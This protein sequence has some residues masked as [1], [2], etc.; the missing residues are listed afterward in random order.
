MLATILL[1]VAF[2]CKFTVGRNFSASSK[3]IAGNKMAANLTH[4]FA[5]SKL[6]LTGLF[7]AA[8]KLLPTLP[9]FTVAANNF[10]ACH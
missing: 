3:L 1:L 10:V 6:L 5:A 7:F 2:L 4:F 9:F 8:V